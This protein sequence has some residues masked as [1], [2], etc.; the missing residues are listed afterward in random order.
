[1]GMLVLSVA[2]R[3]AQHIHYGPGT[4]A[5]MYVRMNDSNKHNVIRMKH[6]V[7]HTRAHTLR[8]D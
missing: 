1:M 3:A 2:A 6:C 7:F 8:L 4:T 5:P